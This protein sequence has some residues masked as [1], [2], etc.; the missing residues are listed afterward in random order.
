MASG[1]AL[2]RCLTVLLGNYPFLYQGTLAALCHHHGL[3]G[4]ALV[5]LTPHPD[6]WE[7]L[8]ELAAPVVA[9]V[10]QLRRLDRFGWTLHVRGPW[11]IPDHA[12]DD[13]DVWMAYSLLARAIRLAD[14]EMS[15]DR[16]WLNLGT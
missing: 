12:P 16:Q 15:A 10:R 11:H 3:Q 14:R 8:L 6:A 9:D 4:G 7:T 13:P 2:S 5:D 1:L